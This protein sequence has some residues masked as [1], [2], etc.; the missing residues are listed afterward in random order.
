M[1]GCRNQGLVTEKKAIQIWDMMSKFGGYGFCLPHS[2]EYSMITYW[3]CW[4]KCYYPNEFIA[5]CLTLGDKTKN[6]EYVREAR[7]LGLKINLPKIGISHAIKWNCDKKGNL[8]APFISINGVGENVAKKISE[9]KPSGI[10]RKGFFANGPSEKIPGV[11]KNVTAIL[12]DI[13]AFEPDYVTTKDDLKKYR[14]LFIF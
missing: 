11:N 3:D 10:I 9:S 8:F 5:A 12:N 13:K 4:A 2:V 7:R 14:D 1:Q 6:I